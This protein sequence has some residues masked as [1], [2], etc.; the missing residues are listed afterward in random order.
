MSCIDFIN[1]CQR[2]TTGCHT[3]K[4]FISRNI[5]CKFHNP[6]C[7]TNFTKSL[8]LYPPSMCCH[9]DIMCGVREGEGTEETREVTENW[10][11]RRNWQSSLFRWD[12][13]CFNSFRVTAFAAAGPV[14]RLHMYTNTVSCSRLSLNAGNFCSVL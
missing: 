12:R 7:I 6:S 11:R 1:L 14:H 2:H 9:F 8:P 10:I 4:F 5:P 13:L 3:Q